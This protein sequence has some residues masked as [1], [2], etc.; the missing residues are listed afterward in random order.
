MLAVTACA[1]APP[2]NFPR[3]CRPLTQVADV[4]LPGKPVRFD[5]QDFD[6]ER[7]QLVIAHM[8]DASVVV[9]N[10]RDR[11]LVK[12]VP[13]VPLARGVA[14]AADVGRVFVTSTPNQLVILNRDTFEELGRVET[15][16]SPDGVAWD[17]VHGIVG[18]SDQGDGAVS[19]LADRGDG[20]RRQV[21][22]GAETGNIVFD[23]SRGVFW[24]TVVRAS[25][26]DELVSIEPALAK[27][28]SR[29][30]LPACSGAHGLRLAPDGK[31]AL[32]AC[33]QNAK[34]LRVDLVGSAHATEVAETG[35]GPDVLAV[36]PGLGWLY[37]AAESGEL[38]IFDLDQRRL[39]LV[40]RERPGDGSH[41]VAVDPTTH[42]VFFPLAKGPNGSPVLR[43]MKPSGRCA[44]D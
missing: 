19:L 27:I 3:E 43:I 12:V 32:V 8:D 38:S 37:V 18:V 7:A 2:S 1:I 36:D 44:E 22:L 31:T 21:S 41:S 42:H 11:A 9:L 24:V 5:Y 39:E 16:K 20:A 14:I 33:E 34:L 35:A 26:P 29:I 17:G 6:V 15:G 10:V 28:K 23:R 30:A 4:G 40:A 13:N 25:P